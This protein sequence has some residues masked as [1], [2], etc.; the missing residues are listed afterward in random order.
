MNNLVEQIERM[1]EKVPGDN[2]AFRMNQIT[3]DTYFGP[4]NRD[5]YPAEFVEKVKGFKVRIDNSIEGDVIYLIN[6]EIEDEDAEN[7][8]CSEC[9]MCIPFEGLCVFCEATA[10]VA[11]W[12]V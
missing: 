6:E 11:S 4:K 5:N 2:R 10:M 7:K 3:C 8:L 9:G 1:I 12:E